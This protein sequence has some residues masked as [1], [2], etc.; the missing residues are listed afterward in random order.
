MKK[1]RFQLSNTDPKKNAALSYAIVV[2]TVAFAT[3]LLEIL[4]PMKDPALILLM[5]VLFAALKFGLWPSFA[6]SVLGA[7]AYN[8]FFIPP[9]YSFVVEDPADI[10]A[11]IS[12]LVVA[13]VTSNL[14]AQ[15][16]QQ[17]RGLS[18]RARIANQLYNFSRKV[19]A[20][21]T[22]DDLLPF[23]TTQIGLLMNRTVILLLPTDGELTARGVYPP[24]V[25]FPARFMTSAARIWVSK[26]GR[27]DAELVPLDGDALFYYRVLS[28]QLG[29][30][31]MLVLGRGSP[32]EW[33]EDDLRLLS[34]LADQ[35]AVAIERILLS[36]TM[37]KVKLQA[38]TEKLRNSVLASI[39]HDLRTPLV[40]IIGGL[41]SLQSFDG[42][43]K[44]AACQE[45]LDVALDDAQRLHRFVENLLNI[46]KL[47]SGGLR[48]KTEPND[49]EEIIRR[50]VVRAQ[51]QLQHHHVSLHIPPTLPMGL[52]DF[53]L[54][55]QTMFN[56]VENAAKYAPPH[57]TI[58]II[59]KS[60]NKNIIIEIL[61][62][63]PGIPPLQVESIF[64][65]FTRLKA[66][67][68]QPAGTG[69]GLLI[70]RGFVEAMNGQIFA[71]NRTDGQ[72]AVFRITLPMLPSRTNS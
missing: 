61:D 56:L 59:T 45:L 35:S 44:Q 43:Y 46:T 63:G 21:A 33:P 62:Q 5:P 48:V 2:L 65:K 6:A 68:H 17:K 12:F 55:E 36:E 47:E 69:L 3:G 14:V 50:A 29:R 15:I 39:S 18:D 16:Q 31:G 38:E 23:V 4:A 72:G 71:A 1:I 24:K 25:Q 51:G 22:L 41:S 54:L 60:D 52:V 13:L 53:V 58:Q 11:L 30:V 34:S 7:L 42:D 10:I 27:I 67:D 9:R 57:S 40:S 20:I 70:C 32:D 26:W 49:I 28:T 37:S 64:N 8:F 19:V 66:G